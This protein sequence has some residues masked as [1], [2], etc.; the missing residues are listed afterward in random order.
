MSMLDIFG[1][2]IELSVMFLLDHMFTL[3][4]YMLMSLSSTKICGGLS[5]T[6]KRY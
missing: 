3:Y 4:V 6:N 5:K 1:C 2:I